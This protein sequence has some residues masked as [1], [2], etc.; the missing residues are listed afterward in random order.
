MLRATR[1]EETKLCGGLNIGKILFRPTVAHR[2]NHSSRSMYVSR[3]GQNARMGIKGDVNATRT[4]SSHS[5]SFSFFLSHRLFYPS[6]LYVIT[7]FLSPQT[8]SVIVPTAALINAFPAR[9]KRDSAPDVTGTPSFPPSS[10]IL[11]CSF[12][13]L[14]ATSYSV[15][16]SLVRRRLRWCL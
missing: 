1:R 6:A 5:H 13:L 9:L 8:L 14:S 4:I 7:L 10:L 12:P 2:R 3:E 15:L 16:A 11:F